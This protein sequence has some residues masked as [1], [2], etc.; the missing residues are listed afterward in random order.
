MTEIAKCDCNATAEII[1][2]M[3]KHE[4]ELVNH[5]ITWL[6][7]LQGLLFA[8]LG[9][10]WGKENAHWL[11][12]CFCL[13]GC[14]IALSSLIS[15]EGADQAINDMVWWWDTHKPKDFFGPDVIGLTNNGIMHRH[16]ITMKVFSQKIAIRKEM[17]PWY[18]LPRLF[19]AAWLA[20]AFFNLSLPESSLPLAATEHRCSPILLNYQ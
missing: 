7:H 19:I 9:F 20:I 14:F 8:A 17:Y 18:L 15:L 10:A 2:G 11:V 12:Y 3:I 6:S 16:G 1:R 13:L 5:R 4:N